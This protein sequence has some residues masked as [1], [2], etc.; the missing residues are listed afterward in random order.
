LTTQVAPAAMS[1]AELGRPLRS[2]VP[3]VNTAPA[4]WARDDTRLWVVP[5]SISAYPTMKQP[6]QNPSWATR[7]TG[8]VGA[9][10]AS[11]PS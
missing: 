3:T 6:A 8:A 4:D 2:M 11:L 9:S 7:A 5:S 10:R 1:T